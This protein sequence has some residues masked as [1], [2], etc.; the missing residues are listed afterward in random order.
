MENFRVM[1]QKNEKHDIWILEVLGRHA[2]WLLPLIIYAGTIAPTVTAGD[3]GEFIVAAHRFSLP[4]PPGYPLYITL[5]NVWTILPLNFGPDFYAVKCHLFSA[6]V[7]SVMCGLFYRLARTVTGSAAASLAATLL[8]AIS[9]T[10]WKFAVVTEVY[11][12][13]LLLIV[14]VLL[15]LSIA[16]EGRKSIGL[17][18][19]AFAF[20][21][22]LAHHHT[23][24]LLIPMMFFLWPKKKDFFKKPVPVA[25]IIAGFILPLAFYIFLPVL[26]SNTPMYGERG[27][28]AGDFFDTITRS[29]IRE[30][31]EWQDPN[32][33]MVGPA[34][35]V[36]R[37]L[38]YISKQFGGK[39]MVIPEVGAKVTEHMKFFLYKVFRWVV[40]L[41]CIIGW[42]LAPSGK[43]AWGFWSA[44]TAIIWIIAVSFFSRGSP[45]GMPFSFLRSI[46]EFLLP[47]NLFMC[48]GFAWL[49]APIAKSLTSKSDIGGTEGQNIIPPE[50]IPVAIMLLMCVIP[51][52][53]SLANYTYSNMTHH[54]FAQDQAK[55]TLMQTP[56]NGVLV[57]SGDESFLFEYLMEVREFRPDIEL[58][59]YPFAIQSGNEILSPTD[60]LAFYLNT[61]LGGRECVF[62]FGDSAA[63]VERLG[64]GKALRLDGIAFTLVDRELDE[65]SFS[66]GD[67]DIWMTY[68]LRNLEM[69]ILSGLVVDDFEYEVFDRYVNGLRASVAWLDDHGFGPDPS[70]DALKMMVDVLEIKKNET[71]YPK[72]PG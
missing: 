28:N 9:R 43:R 44:V 18:I 33:Q 4:H 50:Y 27:F 39:D 49:M 60:S 20:G 22:G 12:L 5:L 42:F 57:V 7:M 24:L 40:P 15:G 41:M 48:L 72:G 3:A 65:P 29:E 64:A 26:A 6:V 56:F 52:F 30:R 1:K 23:I 35:T 62:T 31:T 32:V 68:Q 36:S 38:R 17:V 59:V 67:P 47:V 63:A 61:Q 21:L 19:A 69:E 45:L 66:V 10:L 2:S 16:R 70:R 14:L 58:L 46:D 53:V 51:F 71:D 37:S 55:N 11:A 54:T 8:L 25:G 34:D 13:H